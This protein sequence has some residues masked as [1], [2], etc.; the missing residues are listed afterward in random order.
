MTPR[1]TGSP[2]VADLRAKERAENF[3]VAL[4]LLPRNY[5]SDLRAIYDVVRVIDDLGDQAEGD[6]AAQLRDYHQDL[7]LAWT[8][9]QP[10]HPTCRRIRETVVSRRLSRQPFDNLVQANLLD[11]TVSTYPTFDDLLHYCALSAAPIGRLVLEVFSQASPEQQQLSDR[12][13][14]ALQLLE[15]WQDVAEDQRAGRTYLPQ[16]DL[17]RFDVPPGD[18]KST[19]TSPALRALM[20]YETVRA[21]EL[22]ESGAA[23]V[24]T[25]HGW[26]RLAV[27]GYLAGGRATVDAL[28]RADGNVMNGPPGPRRSDTARHLIRTL[29]RSRR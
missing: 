3:P 6:R 29:W 18:L 24:A 14:S 15:H 27:A 20:R 10:A 17:A 5:R 23:L 1:S 16:E 13:C 7:S 21:E 2:G 28:R 19:T 12:I 8:M 4:L 26:A 9:E 11:Q 22:M 25:L